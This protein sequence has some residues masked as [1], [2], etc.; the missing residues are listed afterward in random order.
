MMAWDGEEE[1]DC[2]CR[3]D[4]A[5]DDCCVG[6]IGDSENAKAG[7]HDGI[8]EGRSDGA[9][10]VDCDDDDDDDRGSEIV[11]LIVPVTLSTAVI[12]WDAEGKSGFDGV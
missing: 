12:I 3:F 9:C 6:R 5:C 11:L 4:G 1:C 8:E 7:D 2:Q 10:G